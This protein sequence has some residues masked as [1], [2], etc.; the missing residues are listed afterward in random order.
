MDILHVIKAVKRY[1]WIF[2]GVTLLS[3][4]LI[5]FG[6]PTP[7]PHQPVTQ[8]MSQAKILL[9]PP[10]GN[11]NAFTGGRSMVGLDMA[12][13][14]FA[15]PTVLKE[16]LASEEL[17][18][19]V[20]SQ[21]SEPVPW[22]SLRG[23]VQIEPLSMSSRG[24]QLFQLSV[25]SAEPKL[26]QQ[27]SQQITEQ[28]S[29]YVQE[30][31]AREFA[32][33]RKFIEELVLEADERRLEVEDKLVAIRELY[34]DTPSD[35]QL[36]TDL[37]ALNSQRQELKVNLPALQAELEGLQG[38]LTGQT[39]SPPWSV[40]QKGDAALT[41]LESQVTEARIQLE[42][43]REIYT[44]ENDNV[45]SAKLRLKRSEELYQS[46][47]HEYAKSLYESKAM[48]MQQIASREQSLTQQLNALLANQMTPEDRRTV[49]KLERE[50]TVW[51]EN[52]LALTQ[53]LYQARVVEQSSRRQGSVTVLEQPLPG[54]PI[55]AEAPKSR[56]LSR[57]K[58]L[59]LA[60]PFC[61]LLGIGAALLKDYLSTSMKLRPRIEEILELPV[62]AVIPAS[63]SELVEEWEKFK[64]PLPDDPGDR[65]LIPVNGGPGGQES[66]LRSDSEVVSSIVDDF[67]RP[68]N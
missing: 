34:L 38:Y 9:T 63:P 23:L 45:V 8:Y 27:I 5:T 14:W 1:R 59:A 30:I 54:T 12:Q 7:A 68:R 61:L 67:R 46:G 11:V 35:V 58:K 24:V 66:K 13:S 48:E 4:A 40:L 18:R 62:I 15:D 49:Q 29:N 2:I 53:Q 32:S 19:R 28:F 39:S 47:L 21:V 36:Q 17:L 60:I 56:G 42:Q 57:N 51:E 52:H 6:S 3:L 43:A 26:A 37:A 50:L 65:T 25:T 44:E 22:E 41:S 20:A 16:L 64:R 55:I 31:S 10:S 33:T